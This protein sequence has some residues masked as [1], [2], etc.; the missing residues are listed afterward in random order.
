MNRTIHGSAPTGA[1]PNRSR[2]LAVVAAFLLSPSV[3]VAW[4]GPVRAQA[5]GSVTRTVAITIDD[6]P[7]TGG[8][9]ELERALRVTEGMVGALEGVEARGF[10]T[11]TRV[12]VRGEVDERLDMLRRWREAGVRLE[13]HSWS[14]PSFETTPY[15]VYASDAARGAAFPSLVMSE[16]GDSVT[17]Y[18]HPFNHTGPTL[19]D[20]LRFEAWLAERGQRLTPFTVEHADYVFNALYVDAVEAGDEAEAE[21]IVEAYLAH[22]DTAFAFAEEL[23]LDTFGRE[24]PQVFLIHANEL[25]ARTM[26]EMLERL[27]ARGYRFVT[28][29]EALADPAYRTED[30]YVGRFGISWLHRWRYGLGLPNRLRDEPDPPEWILEAYQAR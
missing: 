1:G 16:F 7:Y 13:N 22:L 10:V 17:F 26:A 8:P 3:M 30:R 11:G 5:A 18:R 29:E 28:L 9:Q 25:N 15:P 6:L 20:R 2:R 12:T 27:R 23:S 4:C 21:R 24:I 14:H 19:A